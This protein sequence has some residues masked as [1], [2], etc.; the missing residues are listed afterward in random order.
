MRGSLP[1]GV[2]WNLAQRRC[3]KPAATWRMGV[4]NLV[5]VREA[6]ALAKLP[7]IEREGWKSLWAK[8]DAL[9]LKAR[10]P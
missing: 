10:T 4:W 7:E 2:G 9:L 6:A 1:R 8:V 3:A 5:G